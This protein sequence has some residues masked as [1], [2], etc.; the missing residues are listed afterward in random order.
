M[1]PQTWSKPKPLVSVAGKTAMDHLLDSFRTITERMPM[2]YVIIYSPGLGETQIPPYMREHHPDL[3]VSYVLQPEMKGQSH[4]LWL[5][6]EHLTGPMVMCF[7]DTLIEADFSFLTKEKEAVVWVKS[8]PDPRRFGVAELKPDG[9]VKRLI[10]KPPT[11]ENDLAMVGCYYF[12]SG[13]ALITAIEE[14]MKRDVQLKGEFFL[15]DA[16]NILLEAGNSHAPGTHHDLA[17][18]RH[19][20]RHAGD[21]PLHARPR[22][23]QLCRG[24]QTP[25]HDRHPAGVHLTPRRQWK[26]RSSVRTPR[27]ERAARCAARS[28]AT[29][30]WRT[31][32]WSSIRY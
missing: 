10:E 23:R 9:H 4:A 1:R 27:W 13:E 16:V 5:A 7:S 18:Y 31:G 8:V 29:A 28:S 14:Q 26:A 21:Q 25:R 12:P 3:K 2:E 11:I 20:Q 24:R 22:A 17:G 30:S 6:R 19:D 32:R 15:A